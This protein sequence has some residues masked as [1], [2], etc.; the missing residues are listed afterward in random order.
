MKRFRGKKGFTIVEL[1]IVIAVIAILAAVLVPTFNSIV[2]KA[3]ESAALQ[4]AQSAL[5]IVTMEEGGIMDTADYYFIVAGTYGFEYSID[6]DAEGKNFR[7]HP[8]MKNKAEVDAALAAGGILA[9][10]TGSD[11]GNTDLQNMN[12]IVYKVPHAA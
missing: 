4:K 6:A 2:D 3:K 9:G 8:V 1:V 7:L 11:F 12:I 5:Q 10:L